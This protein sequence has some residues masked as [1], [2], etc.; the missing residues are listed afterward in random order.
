VSQS[1]DGKLLSRINHTLSLD[2]FAAP[3]Q[4]H[5]LLGVSI[6]ANAVTID[7]QSVRTMA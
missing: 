6:G 4:H 1:T 2:L 5:A 7:V 3:Q